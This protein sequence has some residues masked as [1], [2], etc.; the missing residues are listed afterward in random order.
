MQLRKGKPI[1]EAGEIALATLKDEQ[2][3]YALICELEKQPLDRQAFG[4]IYQENLQS[5]HIRYLICHRQGRVCGFCSLF[6]QSPLHHAGR[7]GEV[8][9]LIVSPAAQ[10]AGIGRALLSK[11]LAYAAQMGCLQLEVCCNLQRPAAHRFYE[12]MGL[13]KSHYKFTLRLS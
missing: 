10:G 6:V 1:K 5:E 11:A 4:R 2:A 7:I 13:Q 8:Q 3:V 12:Y 9:E